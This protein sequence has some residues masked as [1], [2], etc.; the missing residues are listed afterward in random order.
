M[1][2]KRIDL[3]VSLHRNKAQPLFNESPFLM[4]LF[5]KISSLTETM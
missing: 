3:Q 4:D 2:Q 1:H 5:S